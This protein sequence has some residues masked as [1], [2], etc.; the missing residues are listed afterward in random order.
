MDVINNFEE[1]DIYSNLLLPQWAKLLD[2]PEWLL[3]KYTKEGIKLSTLANIIQ[4]IRLFEQV[5][6]Y[7]T[8]NET[9]STTS[10]KK[11]S[12]NKKKIGRIKRFYKVYGGVNNYQ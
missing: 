8:N 6:Q 2:V 11:K 1:K 7:S 5:K 4:E 10:T 9:K 3:K 12:N